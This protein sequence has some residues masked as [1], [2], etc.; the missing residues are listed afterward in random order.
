MQYFTRLTRLLVAGLGLILALPALAAGT[1]AGL[2]VINAVTLD[3]QVN[4][5]DQPQ[6]TD[7]VEFVVDRK[8]DIQVLTQDADWI[9]APINQ[10]VTGTPALT[11]VPALNFL[12]SNLSNADVDVVLGVAEQGGI[13]I[14][15]F[16]NDP[17]ATTTATDSFIVAIPGDGNATY[18][19]GTDVVLTA[20]GAGYYNL[21]ATLAQDDDIIVMV[22]A[23]IAAAASNGDYEA[24]SLIAGAATGV[25][26]PYQRDESGNLAPGTALAPTNN[27]D[28]LASEQAVFGDFAAVFDP[29]NVGYDFVSGGSSLA[30]DGNYDGQSS[31]T[32]GY[33][34]TGVDVLVAKYAEVIYDP[35][36]DNKY[37]GAG[38]PTGAL[39]KAI[40]GAVIMYVVGVTNRDTAF[41]AD[42]INIVDDIPDGAGPVELVDE[43][44]QTGTAVNLPSLVTVD[45][46]PGNP[47]TITEDFALSGV[48]DQSV[49]TTS[50]CA[51]VPVIGTTAFNAAV[52]PDPTTAPE[53][54]VAIGTCASATAGFIVYF[55]TVE[56]N[57]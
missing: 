10:A 43:G 5:G 20:N 13:A 4:G 33:S 6:L 44:N 38:A 31:D 49:I 53:V 9:S 17:G 23:D 2:S 12:V 36:S 42:E 27:V 8:L 22:V 18:D 55:V 35:I 54:A 19:E 45:F 48:A 47:G 56:T 29:E 30:V 28:D 11:G 15:G 37:S 39:P 46:D 16:T 24:F 1:D 57:G 34:I 50:S 52:G 26:T 41:G 32:S 3:Y 40:P 51:V 14:T 21:P 25:D 7:S